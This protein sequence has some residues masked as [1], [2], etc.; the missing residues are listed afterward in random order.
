MKSSKTAK[1]RENCAD[2][3]CG[4]VGRRRGEGERTTNWYGRATSRT[5]GDARRWSRPAPLA[6]ARCRDWQE[7]HRK[8]RC[9]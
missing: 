8:T 6:A 1:G 2:P 7:A 9:Q 3:E 5:F 4:E